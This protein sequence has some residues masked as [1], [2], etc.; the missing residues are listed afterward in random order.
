MEGPWSK[1][2][3]KQSQGL[4]DGLSITG[5]DG[6]EIRFAPY[7]EKHIAPLLVQY[8]KQRAKALRQTKG[9][10]NLL[11]HTAIT[12]IVLIIAF[13]LAVGLGV[14]RGDHFNFIVALMGMAVMLTIPLY[15]WA[16]TAE[17]RYK[18][19]VKREIFPLI[20]GFFG[21]DFVYI[22]EGRLTIEDMEP[23]GIIPYHNT[24]SVANYVSGSYQ[25]CAFELTEAVM[26]VRSRRH[27]HTAFKGLCVYLGMN[28]E[29]SSHTVVVRDKTALGNFFE[30]RLNCLENVKLED[31]RFEGKF[32]IY[33]TDQIEA[34]YLLTPSFME[35][36]MELD[37]LLG[38]N[39]LQ[40]SLYQGKLLLMIPGGLFYTFL[41]AHSFAQPATF[42]EEIQKIFIEMRTIFGV[43]DT[44]K[45]NERTGL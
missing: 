43:I 44:L 29:F 33:S 3:R 20:F 31:P 41:D 23:S 35:R 6:A 25:G 17:R 40:A 27:S 9:R 7:Y 19:K 32:E 28:K 42:Y 16:E 11:N 10:L 1:H 39:G 45:L 38:I 36:L 24:R 15:Q 30:D 26:T 4:L 21:A 37:G 8:E 13:F 22:P 2:A 18:E 34:R 14:L 12:L 5:P